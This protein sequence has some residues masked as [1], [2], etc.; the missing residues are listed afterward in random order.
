MSSKRILRRHEEESKRPK[1]PE[2]EE[3]D[4]SQ[5]I[6]APSITVPDIVFGDPNYQA[7]R[8]PDYTPVPTEEERE[9]AIALSNIQ[10][11]P[12]WGEPV[13]PLDILGGQYPN[14]ITMDFS[15]T[16]SK[17]VNNKMEIYFIGISHGFSAKPWS[18]TVQSPP[19]FVQFV[20][21][22]F[23]SVDHSRVLLS[24]SLPDGTIT[25][26][27]SE[28]L[29][30]VDHIEALS[31][32][33]MDEML[34]LRG[35]SY[36]QEKWKAPLKYTDGICLGIYAKLRSNL[37]RDMI[38][39]SP[40]RLKCSLKLTCTYLSPENCGMSFELITCNL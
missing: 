27:P 9:A 34:Q 39:M 12:A 22:K 1:T 11:S 5:M 21:S 37:I 16:K 20:P 32:R 23:Q 38:R 18:Y 29:A 19:C 14:P 13:R 28:F 35:S 2:R 30:F 8:T 24:P 15:I 40:N 33:L 7:P 10:R 6:Q 3:E 17:S 26:Y 31:A 36:I 4:D 25:A